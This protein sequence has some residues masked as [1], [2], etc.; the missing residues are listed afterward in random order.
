MFSRIN[1]RSDLWVKCTDRENIIL[2]LVFLFPLAGAFVRHWISDL[3]ALLFLLSLFLFRKG[4]KE[5]FKKEEKIFLW[6]FFAYFTVF[7]ITSLANGWGEEQTVWLLLELRFLAVIPIYIMLRNVRHVGQALLWGIMLGLV[8]TFVWSIYELY[9]MDSE[10]YKVLATELNPEKR[11]LNGV[12]SVLFIGP[13]VLLLSAFVIPAANFLPILEKYKWLIIILLLAGVFMVAKSG[14]RNAYLGLL[15]VSVVTGFYYYHSRRTIISFFVVLALCL[16]L[17]KF[18]DTVRTRISSAVNQYELYTSAEDPVVLKHSG[19]SIGKRLELWRAAIL[20]FKD[21]PIFGIGRGNFNV[22]IRKL[23][24]KGLINPAVK[25]YSQPHN[26]FLEVVAS[27][28]ILGLI[29]LLWVLYYPLY[30]FIKTRQPSPHTALFGI[31]HILVITVVSLTEAA[32]FIKGNFVA[33]YLIFLSVFYLWHVE[34]VYS[35]IKDG[36]LTS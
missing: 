34:N 25:E 30:F 17:W 10:S 1:S 32:T 6:G 14:A 33:T 3:F 19:G 9:I 26:V 15:A 27:R 24:D 7:I 5:Q 8:L 23:V 31:L 11:R 16:G 18:S 36:E 35:N 20:M 29:V 22:E 28:G 13:Y 21:N 2:F 4:Q 12:Y